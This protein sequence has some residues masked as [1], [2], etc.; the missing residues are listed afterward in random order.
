MNEIINL[1]VRAIFNG[2]FVLLVCFLVVIF[3]KIN[4]FPIN[5]KILINSVGYTLLLGSILYIFKFVIEF[6]IGFFSG[7]EY[8]QYALSNRVVGPYWW[9]VWFSTL[10]PSVFLSQMLWI[11]RFKSSL[12]V[13]SVILFTPRILSLF[14][15]ILFPDAKVEWSM[16]YSAW[17]ITI[18]Y[19]TGVLIYLPILAAVYM[20]LLLRKRRLEV[21]SG[22]L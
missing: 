7:G 14:E 12:I 6:Y 18:D 13:I 5:Y 9:V 19:V 10:V 20:I 22:N 17:Q 3:F 11:K 21:T 8:E 2:S 16:H 1:I 4:I 15:G